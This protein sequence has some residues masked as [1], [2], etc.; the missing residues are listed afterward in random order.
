[1]SARSLAGLF[2]AGIDVLSSKIATK[3][4]KIL[5]QTGSVDGQGSTETD[6]VELWQHIGFISRPPKVSPGKI[7]AQAIVIRTGSNDIAIA[8]QDLRGLE[9]SG[10]LKEGETG[11]YAAGETG[12]GQAR[13]LLKADGSI[14]LYTRNENAKDGTGMTIQLDAQAGCIRLID[15]FGNALIS[16]PEGW[17]MTS[18][19]A[20][21]TL[22]QNGEVKLIGSGQT[23]IDGASIF[24]GAAG[25]APGVTNVIMGPAGIAGVANPKVLLGLT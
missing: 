20:A 22:N 10:D 8:S 16:G 21:L 5:F 11:I 24:L 7:A 17:K 19:G 2:Q 18:G 25:A 1:V 6:N 4:R 12:N 23:Q 15:A 13:I 14:H 3:T 9:L